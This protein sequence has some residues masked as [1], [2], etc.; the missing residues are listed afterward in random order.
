[1]RN[2]IFI[3]IAVA[4]PITLTA[5]SGGTDKYGCHNNRSTG[6][7]HC[8]TPKAQK[9]RNYSYGLPNQK[10]TLSRG[11]YY[12]NCAHARSYGATPLYRGEPG[13]RKGLDRDNDG[14]ACE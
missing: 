13:Y 3:A 5:H 11:T 1:M 6:D 14:I 8:H 4:F 12:Q 2:Y 9:P 10:K 7:Y